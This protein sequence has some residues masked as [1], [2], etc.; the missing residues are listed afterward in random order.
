M[1]QGINIQS[2]AAPFDMTNASEVYH[3]WQAPSYRADERT[4]LS[5]LKQSLANGLNTLR[6]ETAYT[7]I[8]LGVD[9]I[10]AKLINDYRPARSEEESVVYINR[11]KRQVREIVSTLS[12]LSPRWSYSSANTED[13]QIVHVLNNRWKHWWATSFADRQIKKALQW[14]SISVGYLSPRWRLNPITQ[15][16]DCVMDVLGPL[17]VMIDQLG[18]D[19]ELQR[20]Y[21]VHIKYTEPFSNVLK[22]WWLKRAFIH[23]DRS[24]APIPA[25]GDNRANRWF[26]GSLI[27]RLFSG[28]DVQSS[29][30]ANVVTTA[31]EVDIFYS[32]FLDS[33]LNET[34]QELHTDDFTMADAE[35]MTAGM[36]WE[37][38]VPALGQ[39][40][41]TGRMT[42][43]ENPEAPGTFIQVPETRP[44]TRSEAALYPNRRLIIWC[45]SAVLYDGPSFY[46]HGQ[47]P[48]VP[49]KMDEWPW[50]YLGYSI[51]TETLTVNNATNNLISDAVQQ[52]KL[53]LNPPTTYS[54]KEYAKMTIE[55][56]RWRK[57][58]VKV[59]KTG[60]I[61]TPIT[62]VFPYQHYELPNGLVPFLQFLFETQDHT[63]GVANYGALMK[64]GQL[65]SEDGIQKILDAIGPLV[66]D[67]ARMMERSLTILGYQVMWNL[68]QFDNTKRRIQILGADGLVNEDFDYDP[69]QFV[70]TGLPNEADFGRAKRLKAWGSKFNFS[71]I[72][73]SSF[74][75]TDMNQKLLYLQLWRDPKNYPID[76]W[77]IAEVLNLPN[78]GKPPADTIMDRWKA[79]QDYILQY[80][81]DKQI[82]AQTQMGMAQ[83]QMQQM[84]MMMQLMQD[85]RMAAMMDILGA[86]GVGG[87]GG[88][89]GKAGQP[90]SG[91]QIPAMMGIAPSQAGNVNGG[92]SAPPGR[93][94][95]GGEPPKLEQKSDLAG[96]GPRSTVTES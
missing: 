66:S 57:P 83:M 43:Q 65:P 9:T 67:Q 15:Q 53:R 40:I 68:F 88:V 24:G 90:P 49:F 75:I 76:P 35:H 80:Q 89:G 26:R 19:N 81:L 11:I 3:S 60:L 54:L 72:P 41:P 6:A 95:S 36:T 56:I 87:P 14:A 31:P 62:P 4:K 38:T 12:N 25:S 18:Q 7:S 21:G 71:I 78:F 85:P 39:P 45:N 22:E 28:G 44:A 29:A 96:E 20:A 47:V 16:P 58:G 91:G 63:Q 59:A 77:T 73:N 23:P 51:V 92:G 5:F 55:R 42:S 74:N 84:Q 8:E 82:E 69:G 61:N 48:V 1:A 13:D 17:D 52:S 37:Y 46:V 79:W 32:Y 10:A 93:P 94:P 86:A 30:E 2:V 34:G 64:L 33:S 50:E 70:P 27:Y